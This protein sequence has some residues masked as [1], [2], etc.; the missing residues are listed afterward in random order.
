MKGARVVCNSPIKAI[1]CA[2]EDFSTAC[3]FG[4]FPTD[5]PDAISEATGL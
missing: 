3:T 4:F 5:D 2:H 1:V